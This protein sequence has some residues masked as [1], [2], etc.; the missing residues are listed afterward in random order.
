MSQVYKSADDCPKVGTHTKS[1]S[2]YGQWDVWAAKKSKRHK[3]IRCPECGYFAIWV[4]LKK[5]EPDYLGHEDI[6]EM[7]EDL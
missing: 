5:D 6:R 4:R 1:P 3:Q 2:G 7:A